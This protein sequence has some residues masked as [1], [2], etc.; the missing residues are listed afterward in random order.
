MRFNFSEYSDVLRANF[1]EATYRN[2]SQLC[3]DTA[4]KDV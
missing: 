4:R 2:F 1:D 3:V